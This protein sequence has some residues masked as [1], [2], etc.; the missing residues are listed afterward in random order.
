MCNLAAR[1]KSGKIQ[2]TWTSVGAPSY[3][4][5]R[6]TLGPNAGFAKIATVATTYATYLDGTVVNGTKYYYRVIASTGCGSLAASATATA[7]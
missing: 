6:S 5:Y 4:V 7:R 1:A 2:L 3:D